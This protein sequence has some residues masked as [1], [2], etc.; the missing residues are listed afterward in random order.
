MIA[1]S[2][3]HFRNDNPIAE[4][5]TGPKIMASPIYCYAASWLYFERSRSSALSIWGDV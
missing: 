1:G 4:T 3:L 5:T 2:S